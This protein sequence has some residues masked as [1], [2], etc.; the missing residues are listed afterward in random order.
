MLKGS[1]WQKQINSKKG[2]NPGEKKESSL[3]RSHFMKRS[4][5]HAGGVKN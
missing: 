5:R 4:A 3:S 2:F 1:G